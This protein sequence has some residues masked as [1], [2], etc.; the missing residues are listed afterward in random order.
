MA[1]GKKHSNTVKGSSLFPNIDGAQQK[2]DLVK[3]K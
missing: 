2:E 3:A 1:Y